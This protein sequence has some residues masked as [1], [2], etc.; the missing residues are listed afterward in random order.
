[1]ADGPDELREH[2]EVLTEFERDYRDY[3]HALDHELTT[4]QSWYHEDAMQQYRAA[5]VRRVARAGRAM[6]ASGVSLTLTPPPLYGGPVLTDFAS[7]V[8]AHETHTY[9]TGN[10]QLLVPRMLLDGMQTALGALEDKLQQPERSP[11]PER[12]QP[13]HHVPTLIGRIKHVPP[14][15]GFIADLGGATVVILAVGRLVGIW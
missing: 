11:R 4:G 9:G 8:F 5:L 1:M 10:D 14:V 15:I 13:S 3:V 12:T 7:Q 2:I 6:R